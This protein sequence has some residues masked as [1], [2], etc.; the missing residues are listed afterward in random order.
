MTHLPFLHV[1][2]GQGREEF[3]EGFVGGLLS[4]VLVSCPSKSNAAA[5]SGRGV[6]RGSPSGSV[7]VSFTVSESES[8]SLFPRTKNL[9]SLP[10]DAVSFNLC[11]SASFIV[12]V[13]DAASV[14]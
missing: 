12:G 10:V 5:V 13:M 4:L 14:R 3:V 7:E 11:E 1:N 8:A 6:G 2:Q 9:S